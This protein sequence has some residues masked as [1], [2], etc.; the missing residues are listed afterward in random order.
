MT[1]IPSDSNLEVAALF[2]CAITTG[3]G[4]IENNAKVKIG[5]SVVVFGAGG[6]G[7][8]IVQAANLVGA[9]P[10]IAIDIFENRLSLAKLFGATHT[11]N[12]KNT[13]AKKE[14]QNIVG[15]NQI[16]H[17]I[18]NTG[19]PEIIEIGYEIIKP[20]GQLTLVG[21]PRVG[22]NINIFSLPM[23]FGK[24]IIGSEGGG[25]LPNE[26]IP[27]YSNFFKSKNIKLNKLITGKINLENINFAIKQIK[28]GEMTGR[29]LIKF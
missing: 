2:G 28:S 21:V 14:I 4:V 10:V 11:I 1:A 23:H 18:D 7:L 12:S 24:K 19:Q 20:Q 25:A 6:V 29:C 13:D 26:S 9:C 15:N 17:F 16:D 27:R 8:N 5:E 22:K 3:F